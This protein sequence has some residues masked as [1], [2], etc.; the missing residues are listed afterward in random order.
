MRNSKVLMC[1]AVVMVA[2]WGCFQV[3]KYISG[4]AVYVDENDS[5][6]YSV[7]IGTTISLTC[8]SYLY[9]AVRSSNGY[10]MMTAGGFEGGNCTF[11][12]IS[13]AG[14]YSETKYYECDSVATENCN[15]YLEPDPTKI[16]TYVGVIQYKFLCHEVADCE[17]W[18]DAHEGITCPSTECSQCISDCE[19]DQC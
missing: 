1:V 7:P 2:S 11:N 6:T 10:F 17:A 16:E 3:L 4:I 9:D 8:A 12:N 14:D 13:F 15:Y 18:C 5:N 19:A